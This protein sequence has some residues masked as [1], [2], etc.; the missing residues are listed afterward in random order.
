[1]STSDPPTRHPESL[2]DAAAGAES[3]PSRTAQGRL[4]EALRDCADAYRA[5]ASVDLALV[6]VLVRM[7]QLEAAARTLDEHRA[8]LHA[9]AEDLQ[10]VVA[11]AAVER[12]AERV[13][14][15]CLRELRPSAGHIGG[16]RRRLVA[17]TG[18]AAVFAALLLP[19]GRI[20]PRTTLASIEGRVTHDEVA[21]ARSRLDAARLTAD[22]LRA[23]RRDLPVEAPEALRD[24]AVRKQVRA[25]L[26]N[27]GRSAS[28]E[29]A[30]VAV[31]AKVRAVRDRMGTHS[32]PEAADGESVAPVVP[33]RVNESAP[34][35]DPDALV[36][37]D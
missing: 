1:M 31:L 33:L 37:P 21:A 16:L 15:T 28:A 22:A 6:D 2:P 19:S 9:L 13:Y 12:E 11:D 17:L 5:D 30:P 8:S 10:V 26:A 32:Q 34:A 25:I 3:V 18:A 35:L 7:D 4:T 27:S 20:F 14:D 36:A 29:A 24:P 23:D